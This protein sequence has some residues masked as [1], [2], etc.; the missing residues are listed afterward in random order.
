MW[1]DDFSK[2]VSG[3]VVPDA[4]MSRYTS[5]RVG[6]PAD[7]VFMPRDADDLLR[8]LRF[9]R[10]REIG[11][12]V[13]GL[14]TNLLVRDSGV[15]GAVVRVACGARR[16]GVDGGR[17]GVWAGVPLVGLIRELAG[18]GLSGLEELAGIP[19]T[20]GGAV[21]MNAGAFGAEIGRCVSEVLTIG[22][23]GKSRTYR[24]G[25]CAFDY[26]HSVFQHRPGE[27]IAEVEL[28]LEEGRAGDIEERIREVL[29]ERRRKQPR[30]VRTAGSAFRNPPGVAAAELIEK[31]SLKGLRVG[32]AVVSRKHANFIINTGGAAC[33]DVLRLMEQVQKKVESATGVVLEPEVRIIP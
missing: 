19:G 32:G 24:P 12:H 23:D 26:R 8:A 17:V 7:A 29:A 2:A 14:G 30:R 5:M 13:V 16:V 18:R 33:D 9:L 11:C 25:D 22:D 1:R 3:R 21:W 4:P 28:S 6:G 20:V 31:A 27:V 10:E 15:R